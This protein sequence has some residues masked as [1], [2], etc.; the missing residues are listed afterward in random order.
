M[1]HCGAERDGF[2][3]H[4]GII[5]ICLGFEASALFDSFRHAAIIRMRPAAPL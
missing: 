5:A 2:S 4:E 3:K 1:L